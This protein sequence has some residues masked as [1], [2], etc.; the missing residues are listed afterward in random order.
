MKLSLRTLLFLRLALGWIFLYAGITKL[1]N[2]F[3]TA[4]GLLNHAQTLP[5]FYHWLA[6]PN[7]LPTVNAINKWSLFLLGVSLLIGLFVG[8][9]SRLGIVLMTLYYL[10]QLNF[11][12]AGKN[13]LF[14]DEHVI[15]VLVLLILIQTKAGQIWGLDGW[16]LKQ[17]FCEKYPKIR[18]LFG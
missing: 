6:N 3:W 16:C 14:I 8:L 10:P 7:L 2:P 11:P 5:S 1:L 18:V 4:D 9:S 13:Y 15:F 17:S 12:Y